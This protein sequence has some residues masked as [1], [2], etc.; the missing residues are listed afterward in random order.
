[1]SDKEESKKFFGIKNKSVE[2]GHGNS[3]E[4]NSRNKYNINVLS[5]NF[6]SILLIGIISLGGLAWL[7]KFI[8]VGPDGIEVGF[9]AKEEVV[10]QIPASGMIEAKIDNPVQ[11]ERV[12]IEFK[13]CQ[14][15]GT[16]AVN[17][18]FIVTNKAGDRTI[19]IYAN[20]SRIVEQNGHN[21]ASTSVQ[22]SNNRPSSHSSS[23]ILSGIPT[24]AI[25]SF[26]GV[27]S[28]VKKVEALEARF[29]I[30]NSPLKMQYRDVPLN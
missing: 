2:I 27:A 1:M 26:R 29:R 19:R 16:K 4:I 7:L 5:G 11:V 13:E 15:A 21:L 18:S 22:V 9:A 12:R 10:E 8:K 17:C 6:V 20:G 28:E 14:K 23:E 30:E 24:E 25:F 3:G